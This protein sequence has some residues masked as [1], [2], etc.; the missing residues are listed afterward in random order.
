[1]K[2]DF[3]DNFR[4]PYM[5]TAEGKGVFL[6]GVVLG[7]LAQA[8][9]GKAPIDSAPIFKQLN[10]GRMTK[11][12][13]KKHLSK[14][15]GLSR[16]YQVPYAGILESLSAEAGKFLLSFEDRDMG[17]DGNFAFSTAFLSAPDYFFG[18][19]F[20]KEDKKEEE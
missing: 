16:A 4:D 9:A 10:F 19:I 7:M 20:K 14:I 2:L 8:Q 6:A 3:F 1:M 15:P 17:V 18:K 12:D 11:R 13:V 5:T